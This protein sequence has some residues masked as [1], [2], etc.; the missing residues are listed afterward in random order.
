MSEWKEYEGSDEQIEEIFNAGGYVYRNDKGYESSILMAV[1]KRE[2][3]ISELND[4]N[5]THYLICKKHPL[6]NMIER[7]ARTGQPV[8]WRYEETGQTGCTPDHNVDWSR[9]DEFEYS[10]T[11]FEEGK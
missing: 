6:A 5:V 4:D 7:W 8:Y 10:F 2:E 1:G 11:P 3:L 9:Y